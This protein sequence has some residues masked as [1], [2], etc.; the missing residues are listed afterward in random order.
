[1][2]ACQYALISNPCERTVRDLFDYVRTHPGRLHILA[3][4]DLRAIQRAVAIASSDYGA[5]YAA[6]GGE[7]LL[8]LD[9]RVF[10]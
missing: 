8:G 7:V 9:Q 1:M 10:D 2:L 5:E 4:E 6:E 3:P